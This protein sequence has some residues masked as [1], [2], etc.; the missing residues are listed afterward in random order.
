MSFIK[1]L[2]NPVAGVA[3]G[4]FYAYIVSKTKRFCL[5]GIGGNDE[6]SEES[7]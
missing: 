3:V 4:F 7:T 5:S 6:Y 1:E 2:D